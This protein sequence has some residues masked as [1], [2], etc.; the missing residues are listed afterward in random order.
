MDRGTI[1]VSQPLSNFAV[2]YK[3]ANAIWSQ[4]LPVLAVNKETDTFYKFDE[5]FLRYHGDIRAD[6][7]VAREVK[8]FN[9]STDT[10]ACQEHSYKALVTKRMKNLADSIVKLEQRTANSI[11]K[12]I[13]LD[14]EVAAK[15]LVFTATNY[16]TG[17]KTTLVD[18]T[19]NWDHD[20]SGGDPIANVETAKDTIAKAIG[21]KGNT[22][23]VGNEVDTQ[24]RRH[25]D[26]V[27]LY[28]YSTT[29]ILTRQQVAQALGIEKYIVGEM[30]AVTSAAGQATVTKDYVW[31]KQAAILYTAPGTLVDEPSWGVMIMHKLFGT[32]TAKMRKYLAEERGDGA[33]WIEGSS[34]FQAKKTGFNAGYLY[35]DVVA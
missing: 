31:G 24:L 20:E 34:S 17:Y 27:N 4:V 11:M 10:Y 13:T 9:G 19:N 30:I 22:M 25:P 26:L 5:E 29:G 14:L 32:L 12:K 3:Q 18:G 28:R 1:H 15:D 23:V 8:P 16:N 33:Y 7:A 2:S 6:G 21:V 35:S